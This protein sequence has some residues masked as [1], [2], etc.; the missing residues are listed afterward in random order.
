[1][2]PINKKAI[3]SAVELFVEA[4]VGAISPAA[5]PKGPPKKKCSK[6]SCSEPSRSKGLCTNHYQQARRAAKRGAS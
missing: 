4:I 3:R 1:M 6:C 5:Q 2:K